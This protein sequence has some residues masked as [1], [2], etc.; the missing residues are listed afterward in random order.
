MKHIKKWY[1]V[2]V[3]FV[4]F[5]SF[6]FGD[7]ENQ[8]EIDY[9]LFLPDSGNQFVNEAQAMIQ[10][11]NAAKY[12]ADRNPAPGKIS[13]YGYAAD[14]ANDIDPAVLSRQR[15]LFVIEEL[16]KRGLSKDLFADPVGSSSVDLWGSNADEDGRSLN[17][18]VRITLD[19]AILVPAI[20][21]VCD[22]VMETP[23]AEPIQEESVSDESRSPFPWWIIPLVL[24]ALA[25]ILLLALK[26]RKKPVPPDT[27]EAPSI[28]RPEPIAI[29]P[30]M[31]AGKVKV[32]EEEEIRRYAYG[33]YEKR[34]GQNGDAPGDWY[35]SIFELTAYYEAQGYRV[36]LYWEVSQISTTS[37]A[38]SHV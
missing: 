20:A 27:T 31:P 37:P 29:V 3:L 34:C 9:L 5:G 33:L 35:N 26:R 18:R 24:I 1:L 7:D 13:V 28:P 16:Q 38:A 32:L 22:F 19:D 14:F 12:L 23:A 2:L 15:A 4:L 21:E 10:L 30:V 36:L 11:D 25:A 8:E 17:R 6:T